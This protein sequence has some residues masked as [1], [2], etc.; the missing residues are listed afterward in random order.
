MKV[1]IIW[2]IGDKNLSLKQSC[3]DLVNFKFTTKLKFLRYI[4]KLLF[5]NVW[6]W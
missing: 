6:K 5:R 2:Y 4:E 1:D 3:I